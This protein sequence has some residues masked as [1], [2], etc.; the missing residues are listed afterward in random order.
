VYVSA[1]EQNENDVE[2]ASLYD[3]TDDGDAMT[4]RHCQALYE[5]I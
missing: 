1:T 4:R 5:I 2:V 3:S